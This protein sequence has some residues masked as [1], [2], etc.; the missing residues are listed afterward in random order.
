MATYTLMISHSTALIVM[1]SPQV[2]SVSIKRWGRR[3]QR[4]LWIF[5]QHR[6]WWNIL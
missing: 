6:V 2:P 1:P 4:T 5:Q 3:K